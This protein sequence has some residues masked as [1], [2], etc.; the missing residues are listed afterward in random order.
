MPYTENGTPVTVTD[1]L[2]VS[3]VDDT[4]I[5]SATVAITGNFATGEDELL[6]AS[7]AGITGSY[8]TATGILTLTGSATLAEYETAIRT[9]SYQNT[10]D[11]P[12]ALTRTI[13]FTINDGDIDSNLQS[14][15]IEFTAVNDAPVLAA[16]E[17]APVLYT[18]NGA[19]IAV[20]DNLS[21]SDVD[22]TNIESASV[23]ITGNFAAGEDDLLFVDQAGIT[24]NYDATTGI[25]TLTGS[26]SL[27]DY[28]AAIQSVSYE[29]TSDDPSALTR[30]VDFVINDGDA[31]SNL[32]SRDIEFTAVNDAPV[33]ASIE[34]TPT[35][36]TENGS[37]INV[38]S[39]LSISDLDDTEIDSATINISGN[40]VSGEDVLS[41]TEQFGITGIFDPTTGVLT[42]SGQALLSEYETVLRSV[43]Y[44][45]TSD[46][47][48]E[49]T[50]TIDFVVNDGDI[51]S[52]PISRN[53]E[54]NAE[55]DPPV[56]DNIETAAVQYTENDSP[57]SITA[58]LSIDDLDN[59]EI[60]NAT[61]TILSLIHI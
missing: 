30:T 46:N 37:P 1:N 9:V 15:D 28:Q 19:P 24:G 43:T 29:N 55:N 3:D 59:T 25:L 18:E 27:A 17:T 34:T 45:N 2:T 51:D 10:S 12:S 48:S 16:I 23:A 50:R 35:S 36:F 6:F 41:L 21:A 52:N 26:A 53:V 33:L 47:P 20:T 13:S 56:L 14:R 32:L 39:S 7:Q 57:V 40:F 8:D 5:D 60:D 44:Q 22:D 54:I 61:V 4:N 38:T 31:D 42:L 58:S 11:D 49:L